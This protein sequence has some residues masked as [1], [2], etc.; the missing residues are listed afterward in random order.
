MLQTS[1][2][3]TMLQAMSPDN[4]R[5]RVLAVYSMMFMGMAPIG[6]LLAGAEAKRIGAPLTVGIGGF[7]AILGAIFFA[8]SL[9]K[10]RIEARELLIAS[11][12]AAGQSP[13]SISS[14]P[15]S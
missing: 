7:G 11:G 12:M 8:R 2:S 13:E 5:G 3:N 9:P 1:S 6:A 4:L 15:S 14:R 10:F